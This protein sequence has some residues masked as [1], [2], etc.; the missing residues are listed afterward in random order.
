MCPS[1]KKS[2]WLVWFP[3]MNVSRGTWL[4]FGRLTYQ[5]FISWY[6]LEQF[7]LISFLMNGRKNI[8][9]TFPWRSTRSE[10]PHWK[11]RLQATC[12]SN[13]LIVTS[14]H[15]NSSEIQMQIQIQMWPHRRWL[16]YMTRHQQGK[17]MFTV[18]FCSVLQQVHLRRASQECPFEREVARFPCAARHS[19]REVAWFCGA[20]RFRESGTKHWIRILLI[21][22]TIMHCILCWTGFGGW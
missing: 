22:E 5:T 18:L 16:G 2:F 6:K 10:R 20:E 17:V 7:W 14:S 3:H 21:E 9:R 1:N 19:S 13:W 4:P 15:Q 12:C 11:C 8:F